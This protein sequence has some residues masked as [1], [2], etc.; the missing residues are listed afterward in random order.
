VIVADGEDVVRDALVR[1]YEALGLDW[2]PSTVGAVGSEWDVL[3]DALV[4]EYARDH[5]LEPAVLDGDTL[6]LARRLAG[7]HRA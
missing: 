4:A 1:V 5:E 2:D 6:E 7:E 3:R